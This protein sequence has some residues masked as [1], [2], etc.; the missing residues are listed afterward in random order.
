M[1]L[2]QVYS[3][4]ILFLFQRHFLYVNEPSNSSISEEPW[5]EDFDRNHSKA[6]LGLIDVCVSW[7]KRHESEIYPGLVHEGS[8]GLMSTWTTLDSINPLVYVCMLLVEL[9]VSVLL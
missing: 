7:G 4:D 1:F 5:S 3:C 9:Q 8:T 6:A 2:I